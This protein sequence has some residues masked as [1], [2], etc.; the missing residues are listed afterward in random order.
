[1]Y[2]FGGLGVLFLRFRNLGI[3]GEFCDEFRSLGI[4]GELGMAR[5]NL[6]I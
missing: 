6:G 3:E 2:V 4:L 5:R 1:M